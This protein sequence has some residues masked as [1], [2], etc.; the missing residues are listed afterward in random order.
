MAT[1]P[2]SLD[3]LL[4]ELRMADPDRVHPDEVMRLLKEATDPAFT[5]TLTIQEITRLYREICHVTDKYVQKV[6]AS[7]RI[8]I[9]NMCTGAHRCTSRK[10]K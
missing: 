7:G 10:G 6:L 3:T 8:S 5:E 4:A 2:R 9:A 1:P